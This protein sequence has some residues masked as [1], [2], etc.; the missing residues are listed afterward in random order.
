MSLLRYCHCVASFISTFACFNVALVT[1]TSVYC[2]LC[3]TPTKNYVNLFDVQD[4]HSSM[5]YWTLIWQMMQVKLDPR[6]I[7]LL[8][9]NRPL[10][11]GCTKC[12]LAY[13]MDLFDMRGQFFI[14]FLCFVQITILQ[15][16]DLYPWK[17]PD[18]FNEYWSCVPAIM[19]LWISSII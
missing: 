13:S 6:R 12:I 18:R 4:L 2:L 8:R 1:F 16:L 15:L 14:F 19:E 17:F 10:C 3:F 9:F 5:T 11:P 7:S